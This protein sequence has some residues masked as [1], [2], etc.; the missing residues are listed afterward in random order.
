VSADAERRQR[1]EHD[2][3]RQLRQRRS[4]KSQRGKDE[5]RG[6]RTAPDQEPGAGRHQQPGGNRRHPAEDVLQHG[7]VNLVEIQDRDA[8]PD[9]PGDQ[10]E[11]GDG[12]QRPGGSALLRPDADRDPDDVGSG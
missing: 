12:R 11:A 7:S 9:G 3:Q 1:G 10:R 8:K 2:E 5:C 4:G 6:M